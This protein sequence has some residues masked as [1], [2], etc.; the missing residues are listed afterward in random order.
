MAHQ[1]VHTNFMHKPHIVWFE[2]DEA[3]QLSVHSSLRTPNYNAKLGSSKSKKD[4]ARWSVKQQRVNTS[5]E[6]LSTVLQISGVC[7]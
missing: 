5:P 6:I 2:F 3:W 4:T 1:G 7:T